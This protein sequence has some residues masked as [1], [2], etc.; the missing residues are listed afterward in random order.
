MVLNKG[1]RNKEAH[2][3]IR[4]DSASTFGGDISY[5]FD[6]RAPINSANGFVRIEADEYQLY[7]TLDRFL[8]R[9]SRIPE[10]IAEALW[11]EFISHAGID[12][13]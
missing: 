9:D 11:I 2:I 4:G 3:T 13:D 10:G 7:S 12:H 8:F 6:P 5:S 1:A